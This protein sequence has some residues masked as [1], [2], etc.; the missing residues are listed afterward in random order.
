[1]LNEYLVFVRVFYTPYEAYVLVGQESVVRFAGERDCFVVCFFIFHD[2]YK[3]VNVTQAGVTSVP[4][5]T[6]FAWKGANATL[7]FP[8]LTD[9][10]PS[11]VIAKFI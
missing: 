5:W 6:E 1:M 3:E 8:G 10:R 2:V 7:W 9:S 11:V 4:G